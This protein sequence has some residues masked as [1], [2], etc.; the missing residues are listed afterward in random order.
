LPLCN[1]MA[2]TTTRKESATCKSSVSKNSWIPSMIIG[3]HLWGQK[4]TYIYIYNYIYTHD[5]HS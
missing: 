4:P 5:N 3:W 2:S 1:R